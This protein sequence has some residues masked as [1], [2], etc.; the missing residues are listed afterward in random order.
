MNREHKRNIIRA[1]KEANSKPFEVK[2]YK[3]GKIY[4]GKCRSDF[5]RR[6]G[7]DKVAF[8]GV[9]TGR[10]KHT[11]GFCL[12]STPFVERKLK[13]YDMEEGKILTANSYKALASIAKVS[14]DSIRKL[15]LKKKPRVKNF[16]RFYDKDQVN[17]RRIINTETNKVYHVYNVKE[18]AKEVGLPHVMLDYLLNIKKVKTY[19]NWQVVGA[20]IIH[21]YKVTDREAGKVYEAA[22]MSEILSQ[23]GINYAKLKYDSKRYNIQNNLA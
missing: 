6:M 13:L 21:K 16:C 1:V 7:L 17:V 14:S 18:T 19:K 23:L 11:K 20:P 4:R 12:V 9:L 15:F 8:S 22:R 10:I 2:N 3:T 5:C